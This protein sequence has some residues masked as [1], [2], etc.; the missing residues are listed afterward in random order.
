MFQVGL[1]P[2]PLWT[3]LVSLP[4][5]RSPTCEVLCEPCDGEGFFCDRAVLETTK[6]HN[7]PL[8]K[9]EVCDCANIATQQT[10]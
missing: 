1:G 4:A 2:Q 7:E 8:K 5:T 3:G 9:G 6:S 10:H